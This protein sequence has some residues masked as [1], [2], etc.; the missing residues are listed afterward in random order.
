MASRIAA[1]PTRA[2]T[3]VKFCIN[4]G[5]AIGNLVLD[6]PLVR[7]P[8]GGDNAVFL[9]SRLAVFEAQEV[10]ERHR[11]HQVRTAVGNE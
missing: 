2:G 1:R 8:C 3:P 6:G 7:Q 9:G 4:A 10:L 11:N 5:Q